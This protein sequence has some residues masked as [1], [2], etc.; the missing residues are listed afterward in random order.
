MVSERFERESA[1][2][3]LCGSQ[4]GR[5]LSLQSSWPVFRCGVCGLI[6]LS[7][8]P[9]EASLSEF[10]GREYYDAGTTGYG[11]Y[12]KS[13]ELYG[14][15]FRV[16][17]DRRE[18]DLR[19]HVTTGRRLLEVGC[20]HGFLL[21][22]LRSCGWEV[23]G[24]EVSPLA[25]AYARDRFGLS[26]HGG[27]V[28]EARLREG[29]FDAVLLLDV[30]EHL[31][32]PFDT[33]RRIAGLLRP[34]GILVTQCPWELTHWEEALQ[35]VLRGVRTGSIRP[36]S[37]PAHLYFFSP[38]TLDAALEGG[39]FDIVARQS[40]NYGEIRR[41]MSPPSTSSGSPLERAFRI[42]Y[43]RMGLQRLLYAS[44]QRAG[45]G[46]GLIRYASP[47]RV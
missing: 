6:Y 38:R 31:H 11:G 22:H 5:L 25:S 29:S 33:L 21:D 1:G 32:R 39:G 9:S 28:E 8:R 43:F 41:R 42:V 40:G 16:L 3:F 24:V 45:L 10:Y 12:E 27:T 35:A 20:A 13:F 34:G 46:N 26:V 17:F 37:I 4:E 2:C 47:R 30:L 44:A 18:R 23:E 19:K 7:E 15:V 14:D 36:D